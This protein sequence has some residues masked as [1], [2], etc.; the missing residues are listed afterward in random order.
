[1]VRREEVAD[2]SE[3]PELVLLNYPYGPSL[4]HERV[5][6][7]P[8][9]SS[10][11]ER[12]MDFDLNWLQQLAVDE[13][14]VVMRTKVPDGTYL[15]EIRNWVRRAEALPDSRSWRLVLDCSE[16]SAQ[17]VQVFLD[18]APDLGLIDAARHLKVGGRPLIRLLHATHIGPSRSLDF[19]VEAL[20]LEEVPAFADTPELAHAWRSPNRDSIRLP[21]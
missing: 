5:G 3:N 18:W 21:V 15:Q 2:F 19:A 7:H 10:W 20:V 13:V 8:R 17:D 14:W 6:P 11:A 9:Y 16:A 4:V 12:R 1:V